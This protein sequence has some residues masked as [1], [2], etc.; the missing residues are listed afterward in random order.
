MTTR[1]DDGGAAFPTQQS[2]FQFAPG[3]TLRDYFAAKAMQGMLA[4]DWEVDPPFGESC[5]RRA[6]CMADLMLAAR[7]QPDTKEKDQ[8]P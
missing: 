7:R 5:A 1:R 8:S 6:Y 2:E 3:M 4:N